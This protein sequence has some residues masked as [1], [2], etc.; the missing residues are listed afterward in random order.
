MRDLSPAL[1]EPPWQGLDDVMLD[2]LEASFGR[3]MANV[4]GPARVE[5]VHADDVRAFS[6]QAIAQV[7]AD[8]PRSTGDERKLLTATSQRSL[9]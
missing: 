3:Q 1:R 4:V 2:Q 6:K 5:I 7:G 8:E 9:L